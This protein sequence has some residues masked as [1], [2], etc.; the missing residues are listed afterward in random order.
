MFLLDNLVFYDINGYQQ[1][2]V[3]DDTSNVWK[4][5]VSFPDIS[6]NLFSTQQIHIFEKV[7]DED[8]NYKLTFPK[9]KNNE[10]LRFKFR[11]SNSKFFSYRVSWNSTLKDYFVETLTDNK[12]INLDYDK[13]RITKTIAK[14]DNQYKNGLYVNEGEVYPNIKKIV[15]EFTYDLDFIDEVE[16]LEDITTSE[17]YITENGYRQYIVNENYPQPLTFQL[18]FLSDIE[19]EFLDYLD[20]YLV[21]EEGETKIAEINLFCSAVAEDER[22]VKLLENFGQSLDIDDSLVFRE[23]DVNED[24][25]D[26]IILNEKRKELILEYT[27]IIPFIGSYKGLVNAL[28]YYGYSDL[29]IKEWWLNPTTQQYYHYEIDK[30]TYKTNIPR[31]LAGSKKRTG[32]FSLYYDIFKLTGEVDEY[33]VPEI[34]PTFPF[35]QDEVLIKLYG[36]KELLKN[37]YLPLSTRIVD[38][39]GEGLIFDRISTSTWNTL[40]TINE[41]NNYNIVA[42]IKVEPTI[43]FIDNPIEVLYPSLNTTLSSLANTS[44]VNINTTIEKI[45]GLNKGY[46]YPTKKSYSRITIKDNT[47]NRIVEDITAIFD[48]IE[49]VSLELLETF[50]V[51]EV[52]YDIICKEGKGFRKRIIGKP[53]DLK[54]FTVDVDVQGYYDIYVKMYD[55]YNNVNLTK[56]EKAF[57]VEL[58]EPDFSGVHISNDLSFKTL[59]DIGNIPVDDLDIDFYSNRINKTPITNLSNLSVDDLTIENY[60]QKEKYDIYTSADIIDINR[61]FGYVDISKVGVN[62][63]HLGK[64]SF[65]TFVKE[66]SSNITPK[67]VMNTNA[68][69]YVVLSSNEA[70]DVGSILEILQTSTPN[71]NTPDIDF[72]NKVITFN[73][74]ININNKTRLYVTDGEFNYEYKITEFK[75]DRIL[76]KTIF[77]VED[78]DGVLNKEWIEY[79]FIR[80]SVSYDITNVMRQIGDIV[81]LDLNVSDYDINDFNDGTLL[82]WWGRNTGIVSV[83][84]REIQNVSDYYRIYFSDFE[85]EL[86]LI[87]KSYKFLFSSYD[88]KNALMYANKDYLTEEDFKDAT[89]DELS[90]IEINN[91]DLHGTFL[92]GF[93]ITEWRTSGRFRIG[94]SDWFEFGVCDGDIEL[95][96]EQLQESELEEFKKY[97]FISYDDVIYCIS[98]TTGMETLAI[99]EFDNLLIEPQ[100]NPRY[101]HNYQFPLVMKLEDG[102]LENSNNNRMFWNNLIREWVNYGQ[103]CFVEERVS[104]KRLFEGGDDLGNFK[105]HFTYPMN[106]NWRIENLVGGSDTLKVKRFTNVSFA[107]TSNS[108]IGKN[109]YWWDV[110]NDYTNETLYST[111]SKRF[112]Y[113]FSD[114]GSYTIKLSVVDWNGNKSSIVKEGFVQVF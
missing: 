58:P 70:P 87:D 110:I 31:D 14:A 49:D 90:H 78:F 76:N 13:D 109:E 47:F 8:G 2:Q 96:I 102:Y 29:K 62:L 59:N 85:N 103:T 69:G 101:A 26:N 77:K 6:T 25:S 57:L 56:I 20:V 10:T 106:S 84:L 50:P 3:Y 19:G 44:L 52:Q 74:V 16:S 46:D 35:T 65:G 60:L 4:F 71:S 108:I 81:R 75:V 9:T 79:I 48:E 82:A 33:G 51:Y 34:E 105:R 93:V 98:K 107:D 112:S 40:L 28:K 95:A 63:N 64:Q 32:K 1:P 86:F 72:V 24:L 80:S 41:I 88:L 11:N 39:T 73:E 94:D 38:I 27:N 83:P 91:C 5:E 99:I 67:M 22:F 12:S 92:T 45:E 23:S 17:S 53:Y 54:E 37:K 68:D 66:V 30:D 7:L 61:E 21:S 104:D 36:L 42:D 89:L 97:N 18:G 114:F 55:V 100:V 111:K 15:S 43:N 113:F